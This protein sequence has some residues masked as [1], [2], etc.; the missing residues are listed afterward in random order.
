MISRARLRTIPGLIPLVRLVRLLNSPVLRGAWWLK[1]RRTPLFLQPSNF[2]HSD[3]WPVF[4]RFMTEHLAALKAPRI[5]SFGCS[6][7]EEVFSLR[8]YL[9]NA[10][11]IGID[12]NP[13]NIAKAQSKLAATPDLRIKF[14]QGTA[15]DT[16]AL[17][18]F[19]AIFCMA[20]LRHGGL[21]IDRPARC[22]HLIK[23]EDVEC[24]LVHL[25]ACLKPGGYLAVWS[26]HFR[27]AD[28]VLATEFDTVLSLAHGRQ[29]H[30]PL[31]GPDNVRLPEDGYCEAIFRKR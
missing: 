14:M 10:E 16:M 22:D 1:Q 30:S 31:Y 3:R 6:T 27:F 15:P 7:G 11:L 13:A 17:G 2:T 21:A 23:F 28:T 20:V 12:I 25:A 4:F 9:P 19:D 5:L 8:N 29:F 24:V 26:S 18:E